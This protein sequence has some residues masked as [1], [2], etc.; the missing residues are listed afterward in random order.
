MSDLGK[1]YDYW[2]KTYG[3]PTVWCGFDWPE[4]IKSYVVLPQTFCRYPDC[5]GGPA[6]GYCHI[7]C[8]ARAERDVVPRHLSLE[9]QQVFYAA[10]RKSAKMVRQREAAAIAKV[11]EGTQ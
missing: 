5:D 1:Q 11:E 8:R 2:A 7:G 3:E 10:L 4:I 6:T 9:E